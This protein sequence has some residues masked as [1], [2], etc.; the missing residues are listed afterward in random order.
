[1][2]QNWGVEGRRR[3]T[4]Y[5]GFQTPLRLLLIGDRNPPWEYGETTMPKSWSNK[6]ER[7][8]KHIES[9]EEARGRPMKVAKRIAAAT[10]NKQRR[11]EGRTKK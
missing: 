6:D 2:I 1:V 8:Y 4:S 7:Q 5:G 3:P 9:G 11:R 10:V